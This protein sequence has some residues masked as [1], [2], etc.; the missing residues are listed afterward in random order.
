MAWQRG[1]EFWIYRPTA[2]ADCPYFQP[3]KLRGKARRKTRDKSV[4]GGA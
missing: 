1:R 3:R 4:R 2:T